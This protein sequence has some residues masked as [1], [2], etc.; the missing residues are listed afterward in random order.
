MSY[1]NDIGGFEVLASLGYGARSSI[2][3]VRDRKTGQIYALKRVQRETAVD[4]RFIDQAV[5]EHEIAQQFD[6]PALRKS[7]KLIRKRSLWRTR[8]VI[9]LMEYVEGLTAEQQR[10][11][12]VLE[13]CRICQQVAAGLHA[14]HQGGYVHADIKPNNVI[15][16]YDSR[17][18]L[19]DFGQ[20]CKIGTIKQRI[21]GTPDYIAPEQVMRERIVPQ[22]D[23]FNLG[24]TMY[25]LL[26]DQHV[27]TMIPKSRGSA[28]TMMRSD[29]VERCIP[30]HE[31]NKAIPPALSMLIMSC[32]EKDVADRPK[33]M[34]LLFERIEIA[35]RQ[36]KQ[37][38]ED[39]EPKASRARVS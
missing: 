8:E 11:R 5:L 30:P 6:H 28:G 32:V 18:K 26:T 13:I 22:T 7:Y 19:I 17:V 27:P 29:K 20:S 3:K 16:G 21:Q 4:Q 10:R 9:V 34:K 36:I 23:V 24:A 35:V 12:S 31:L 15:I 2:H 1:S 33:N 25:W 14:M 39:A 38:G 37:G